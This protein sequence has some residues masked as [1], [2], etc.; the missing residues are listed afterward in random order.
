MNRDILGLERQFPPSNIDDPFLD[1]IA[2]ARPDELNIALKR[3]I[4]GFER[5][6]IQ[7]EESKQ[8]IDDTW[9]KVRKHGEVIRGI[10]SNYAGDLQKVSVI[11]TKAGL[12]PP[13]DLLD[14]MF[15]ATELAEAPSEVLGITPAMDYLIE[16][17][18][19]M[20]DETQQL[21]DD[22][23]P[24]YEVAKSVKERR[25][26]LG[27]PARIAT[28]LAGVVMISG[29]GAGIAKADFNFDEEYRAGYDEF[30]EVVFKASSIGMLALIGLQETAYS[31][32]R[33]NNSYAN[34][35]AKKI[36]KKKLK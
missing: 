25:N 1:M 14:K 11:Y 27:R 8:S 22:R 5:A 9:K 3:G 33:A 31:A 7:N 29:V 6:N 17:D 26:K 20:S 2:G 13:A 23:K 12:A 21:M 30:V 10:Y 15:D 36:L 16:A 19:Q 24:A 32:N 28:W 18:S 34:R 4:L 35:K